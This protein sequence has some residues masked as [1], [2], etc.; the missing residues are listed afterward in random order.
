MVSDVIEVRD[1]TSLNMLIERLLSVQDGRPD[2]AETDLRPEGCNRT[3]HKLAIT[4][5]APAAEEADGVDWHLMDAYRESREREMLRLQREV[6]SFA[7][8]R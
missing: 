8:H 4:C 3:G 6:G 1:R 2:G 7:A 5:G